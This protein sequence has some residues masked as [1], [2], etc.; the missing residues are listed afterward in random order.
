MC[1]LNRKLG[2]QLRGTAIKPPSPWHEVIKMN[3]R[4]GRREF[5]N[6]TAPAALAAPLL[7]H[8]AHASSSG[9]APSLQG[10][11]KPKFKRIA[12]EEH[13]TPEDVSLALGRTKSAMSARQV[14]L[15]EIRLAEMDEAGI[16]MQ[17]IANSTYQVLTDTAKAVTLAKKNNDYLAER[18]AKYPKRF[19]GMAALPTQDPKAAADEFERAVK[20]LGFKGAMIE[21]QDHVNFEFLDSQKFWGL[22]ERAAALEAPIY[23]HPAVPPPDSLKI[24]EDK[25]ELR[26]LAWLGGVYTATQALRLMVSGVFD[27]F[28]KATLMLGHMGELLP[29]WLGRL[30]EQARNWKVKKKPSGYVKDN[31]IVTTSGLFLPE[32]MVCALTA[33]GEDRVLFATDYAAVSGKV[34]VEM[35]ERCPISDAVKEKVYH[36]NAERWLRV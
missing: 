7:S 13:W 8:A 1:C 28:P 5:L 22:W 27:A 3:E 36:L 19:A 35:V 31:I 10:A 30:D 16:E 15:G 32:T 29:Y 34:G 6:K 9:S 12:V 26:S 14:D 20:Q 23:L 18:I 24:I 21:G 2:I 33:L 25:P 17:V 11:A 4:T